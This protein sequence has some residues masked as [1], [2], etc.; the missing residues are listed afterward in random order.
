MEMTQFAYI[1]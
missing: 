1:K